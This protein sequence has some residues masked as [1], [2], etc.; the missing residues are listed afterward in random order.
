MRGHPLLL[1]DALWPVEL[2]PLHESLTRWQASALRN[3]AEIEGVWINEAVRA[4]EY[5]GRYCR[6]HDEL[7]DLARPI[8]P[9]TVLWRGGQWHSDEAPGS[10]FVDACWTSTTL[11][12]EIARRFYS[13]GGYT[14]RS[15]HLQRLMRITCVDAV[16][17]VAVGRML[18]QTDHKA[19]L[20]EQEVAL[21]P[22][23]IF[24]LDRVTRAGIVH[25]SARAGEAPQRL[26]QGY[27]HLQESA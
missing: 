4:G 9:G 7:I 23:T 27:E 20:G 15:A 14:K 6:L 13:Q 19:A 17:A 10:E 1:D 11:R 25:V 5:M 18:A 12:R 21:A 22:G 8:A 24:A 2:P 26:W 3:Y 16:S